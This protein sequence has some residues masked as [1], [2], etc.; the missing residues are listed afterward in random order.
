MKERVFD[1]AR[2]RAALRA[3]SKGKVP[4]QGYP[5][6]A[7]R[8]LANASKVRFDFAG[9]VWEWHLA[10]AR[11]SEAEAVEGKTPDKPRFNP[12]RR[13]RRR[14]SAVGSCLNRRQV[15]C[16]GAAAYSSGSSIFD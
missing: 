7:I 6:D 8:F 4:P 2:L 5:F 11:L 10:D 1:G 12:F 14:T 3:A 9:K 16:H 15:V 13:A